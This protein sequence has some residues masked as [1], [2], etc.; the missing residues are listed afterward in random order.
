M[1][2]YGLELFDKSDWK[3][4]VMIGLGVGGLFIIGNVLTPAITIGM[5]SL[6]LAIGDVSRFLVI[7]LL[8]PVAE[9]SMFRGAL[10]GFLKGLKLGLLP[11]ALITA[12]AFTVYHLT[13]YGASLAVAGAYLG[14]FIFGLLA[15]ALVQWRKSLVPAMILHA[16]FNIYL[17]TKMAVVI[18]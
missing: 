8:A 4:D 14:A 7:G 13:A 12:A 18:G 10:S 6:S 15:F 17:L 16:I 2:F 5:P 11:I 9:E 3:K 1:A